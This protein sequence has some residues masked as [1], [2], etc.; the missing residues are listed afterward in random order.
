MPRLVAR[1]VFHPSQHPGAPAT[2]LQ[3][4]GQRTAR[5]IIEEMPVGLVPVWPRRMVVL[6][7]HRPR[8][9]LEVIEVGHAP[10]K[11]GAD[12]P[13]QTPAPNPVLD[14]LVTSQPPI[15]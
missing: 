12:Q 15:G 14:W 1:I 5:E 13:K 7:R 3:R 8:P 9:L 11:P 6:D 2:L 10:A 4:L